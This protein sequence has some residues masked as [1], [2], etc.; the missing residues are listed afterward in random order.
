[1][2]KYF[3]MWG[4]KLYPLNGEE[5]PAET[6]YYLASEVDALIAA[7]RSALDSVIDCTSTDGNLCKECRK[8]VIAVLEL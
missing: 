1:M 4:H 7:Y 2:Q 8:E 5:H 3:T 6:P